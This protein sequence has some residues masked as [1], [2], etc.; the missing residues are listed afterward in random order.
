MRVEHDLEDVLIESLILSAT[1]M[2]EARMHRP[3]IARDD[4]PDAICEDL[5]SVPVSIQNWIAM[6]VAVLYENR[7]LVGEKDLKVM[8]FADSLLDP[9]VIYE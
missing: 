7:E 3:I 4:E 8:R 9:W 2:A 1:Q 6:S 5:E